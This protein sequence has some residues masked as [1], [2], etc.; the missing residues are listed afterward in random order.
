MAVGSDHRSAR[1]GVLLQDDLV[2]DA[3]AGTPETYPVLRRNRLQEIVDFLVRLFGRGQVG[4]RSRL[5][6]DQ[7]VA[8]D[9]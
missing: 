1:K 8:M 3:R 2:D 9:R 5:G 6:H 7:M 4:D